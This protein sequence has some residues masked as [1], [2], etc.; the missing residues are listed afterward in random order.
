[1]AMLN[2]FFGGGGQ[3]LQ[4]NCVDTATLRQAQ[5]DPA[6]YRDLVV[7]VAGFSEFFTKLD[8]DIQEDVIARTEHE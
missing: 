6:E 3:E 2:A 8:P 7:R 1:R 5:A 4:I